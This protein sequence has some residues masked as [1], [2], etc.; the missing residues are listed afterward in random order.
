MKVRF[1]KN[2]NAV[3]LHTSCAHTQGARIDRFGDTICRSCGQVAP[4]A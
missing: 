3:L 1:V 4:G 2:R